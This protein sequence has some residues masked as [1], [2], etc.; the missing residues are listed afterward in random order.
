[1]APFS[2]KNLE[3]EQEGMA[4]ETPGHFIPTTMAKSNRSMARF[5]ERHWQGK[6]H[7]GQDVSLSMEPEIDLS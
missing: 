4:S 7:K 3:L 2:H 6:F 1:M 5:W